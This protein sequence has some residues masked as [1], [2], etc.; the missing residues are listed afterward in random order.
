[1]KL[2]SAFFKKIT[3]V[4]LLHILDL[5]F[6]CTASTGSVSKIAHGWLTKYYGGEEGGLHERVKWIIKNKSVS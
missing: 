6:F 3:V 5:C 4:G 1:M 2:N